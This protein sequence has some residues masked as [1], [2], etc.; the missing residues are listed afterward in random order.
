MGKVA[1]PP[2][3]G[4]GSNLRILSGPSPPPYSGPLPR[5]E[6]EGRGGVDRAECAAG[7]WVKG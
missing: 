2:H 4:Q 3:P 6:L 1:E 5:T 7:A